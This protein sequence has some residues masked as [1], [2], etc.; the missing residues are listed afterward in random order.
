MTSFAPARTMIG[1]L[2]ILGW[3]I[4]GLAALLAI[5]ALV[6]RTGFGLL[7]ILPAIYLAVVG[8]FLVAGAQIGIALIVTAENTD[9]MVALMMADRGGLANGM[10]VLHRPVSEG[11][12]NSANPT[13]SKARRA[14]TPTVFRIG[15]TIAIYKGHAIRKAEAGVTV[16]DQEFTGV[17]SAE[18]HIDRLASSDQATAAPL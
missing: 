12:G 17:L 15:D 6:G 2:S 10:Q 9:R 13:T 11:R 18:K 7:S 5:A 4:V 1:V 3:I 8:L 14:D 16:G